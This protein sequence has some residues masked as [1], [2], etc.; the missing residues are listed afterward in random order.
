MPF[1]CSINYLNFGLELWIVNSRGHTSLTI[2]KVVFSVSKKTVGSDYQGMHH[3]YVGFAHINLN[4][5][6]RPP[7]YTSI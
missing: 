1:L 4:N 3:A 6:S 2:I 5:H 7:V